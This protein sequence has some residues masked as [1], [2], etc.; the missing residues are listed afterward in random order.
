M[1]VSIL[2]LTKEG[3]TK[4]NY[5]IPTSHFHQKSIK[6]I[7]FGSM[8]EF[9]HNFQKVIGIS[10]KLLASSIQRKLSTNGGISELFQNI[11]WAILKIKLNLKFVSLA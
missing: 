2:L 4:L 6:C 11:D 3:K 5:F 1:P 7:K 8:A 10:N 9:H